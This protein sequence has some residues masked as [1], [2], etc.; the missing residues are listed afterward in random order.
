MRGRLRPDTTLDEIQLCR[1]S[2]AFLAFIIRLFNHGHEVI[3]EVEFQTPDG[4]EAAVSEQDSERDDDAIG[5]YH[6]FVSLFCV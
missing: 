4:S 3:E 6:A 1:T 5:V 2:D